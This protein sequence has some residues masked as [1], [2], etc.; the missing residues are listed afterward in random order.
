MNLGVRY[1]MSTGQFGNDIALP[2]FVEAG[3]PNDTNNI[4][5]RLGFA[6]SLTNET[7]LRGGRRLYYADVI[8]NISSR[9]AS[10]NQLAGVELPNDGRADFAANPFNGPLPSK[11]E[12]EA[13]YCSTN[14]VPGCL[15]RSILQIADP[16]AQVPYSYQGSI[17]V[18]HQIRR[19]HGVRGGLRL[20]R[21]PSR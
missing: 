10:W 5:P 17:G 15:R 14:N 1:D 11:S 2:P 4:A 21:Q 13:R 18:Q 9:M 12:A 3:R 7:V 16:N 8:N 6:Y 20:Y 19:V